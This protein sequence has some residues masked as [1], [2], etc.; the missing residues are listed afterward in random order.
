MQ[1][2]LSR[3]VDKASADDLLGFIRQTLPSPIARPQIGRRRKGI[4]REH[5]LGRA[6]RP[7]VVVEDEAIAVRREYEGDVERRRVFEALLYS[8]ADTGEL[9]LASISASGMLG[10]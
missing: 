2:S 6:A 7:G 3:Q 1:Q 4:E 5:C 9:S 8:V 10:L